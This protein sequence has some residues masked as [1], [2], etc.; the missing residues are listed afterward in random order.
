M[1]EILLL[2]YTSLGAIAIGNYISEREKRDKSFNGATVLICIFGNIG[3]W[4][5]LNYNGGLI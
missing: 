3:L 1:Y 5:Y 4:M 2:V